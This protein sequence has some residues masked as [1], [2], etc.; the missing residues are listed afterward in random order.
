MYQI[1]SLA[2]LPYTADTDPH[3]L[4]SSRPI[5]IFSDISF[6]MSPFAPNTSAR[7]VKLVVK[8]QAI[9]N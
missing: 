8:N 2:E 4:H 7:L 9:N 6:Y 5:P 1:R 3:P